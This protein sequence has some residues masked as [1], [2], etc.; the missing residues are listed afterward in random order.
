MPAVLEPLAELVRRRNEP[1]VAQTL[2]STAAAVLS[3][4][5]ALWL[6][7]AQIPLLAPL[8]T[9]LVVQVTL[10][11]TLTRGIRRVNAVVAG[12][13]VA[14]G[15]SN[16]VG[17]SWWSLGI[18]ILA[19]L[20]VGHLVRVKEFVPEV[21]ISAMLVLG[22]SVTQV[23]ATALDRVVETLIGAVVGLLFNVVFVP[24]V[25]TQSATEA[26]EDLASRLRRL[27][28]RVGEELGRHTP[29]EDAAER[30]REAR[31]LD[32][33]IVQVDASLAQAEESLKLNPR[34]KEGLLSRVVLRTG[35]DTLEICVVVLRVTARTLTDLAR[36]RE[37]EPLFPP[38]E[39]AALEELF[40]H[41]AGAV[42]AF[43]VLITSD[44]TADA[45]TAEARLVEELSAAR[46]AR[47]RVADLLL[48][49]VQNHPRQWQLHGALLAEID[50]MLDELDVEKRS[51]RLAEELD[52]YTRETVD[53]HP[54][55][56]KAA[57]LIHLSVPDRQRKRRGEAR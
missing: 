46:E 15:F 45:D 33:D 56:T 47:D 57:E 19:S 42:K 48:T 12:V 24:P 30:L 1:A 25:W 11:A 38:Q 13:L 39:A 37:D 5:A 16:L 10:Y 23:A 32:H 8:T 29:V 34:V 55:L 18:L 43:A 52:R 51:V 6:S 44:V 22:V 7:N 14:V 36:N 40:A 17:L 35:L 50:R 20:T 54:R 2:R 41:L 28:R 4:L 26:I 21:A 53:R 3:Y 9:L 27:L 49:G 31:R